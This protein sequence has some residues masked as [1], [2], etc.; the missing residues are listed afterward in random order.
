MNLLKR[1]WLNLMGLSVTYS[2]GKMLVKNISDSYKFLIYPRLFRS[3]KEKCIYLSISGKNIC[4]KQCKL[5]AVNRRRSILAKC[6][7]NALFQK[8]YTLLK[9]FI[10]AIYVPAKSEI[11][12]DEIVY[13]STPL[14]SFDYGS[15]S[16]DTLLVTPGY[17][18]PEDKYDTAFVHTRVRAYV[19]AGM[20][21]DVLCINDTPCYKSYS[22]EGVNV[23]VA[24]FFFYAN[25]YR[26]RNILVFS[27]IFLTKNM[28]M[29]W[30]LWTPH[31]HGSIFIST[32]PKH[33][34]GTGQRLTARILVKNPRLTILSWNYFQLK[35]IIY[36]STV[37]LKMRSGF[38]LPLGLKNAARSLSERNF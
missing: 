28:R 15:F 4:G 27:F 11:Q 19:S 8:F 35:I 21:L 25:F 3:G 23:V 29:F 10:I 32:E 7:F 20:D 31:K 12:I 14:F 13:S 16:S 9:Y 37:N 17:P 5:I 6:D 34:T 33:F 2:E 1:K 24:N 36:I 38:L 18:S 26:K 30:N 22:Y